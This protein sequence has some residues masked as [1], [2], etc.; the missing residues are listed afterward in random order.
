MDAEETLEFAATAFQTGDLDAAARY[1]R[2]VI[3]RQPREP[4][5][6]A[7]LGTIALLSGDVHKS[8]A[9]YRRA[10]SLRGDDPE[11]CISLAWAFRFFG[12]PKEA[13]ACLRRALELNPH[14]GEA[15]FAL[16]IEHLAMGDYR[17]GWAAYE[18]RFDMKFERVQWKRRRQPQWRGEPL[19]GDAILL[20]AEQG[21]GDTLQFI[22]YVPL[23]AGRGGR[24]I[25]EVQ[26]E[27]RR[28]AAGLPGVERLI[29]PG[30]KAGRVRWQCPLMSL[31]LAFGTDLAS[32]P[33]KVPYLTA[34]PRKVARWSGRLAGSNFRVGLVWGGNPHNPHEAVRTV[35]LN[36]LAPVFSLSG[37]AFYSLQRGPQAQELHRAH[38]HLPISPLD[39]RLGDFASTAA[40]I[41]CMDLVITSDTAVAHLAG[42]LG[43]PV[44]ILLAWQSDWRWLEQ[45][46]DSPWYPTA[47]L[48]RQ[49]RPGDWPAVTDRVRN[50]LAALLPRDTLSFG[51]L[52][53]SPVK[54]L[55]S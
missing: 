53:P 10:R 32:I 45:R 24:V 35:P 7:G 36:A 19:N 1:F 26:P 41:A 5:A 8:A 42:A 27:I 6:H 23:V 39:G 38:R 12:R 51:A 28:L 43:K 2:E 17:R 25:L 37:V 14:C 9:W 48:F 18:S 47:R 54:K 34:A 13:M 31:P 40:V 29:V 46:E 15:R 30:E 11:S 52:C 4:R 20:H 21:F 3:S 49:P 16:A 55:S 33:A 22:R 44:W 50:E